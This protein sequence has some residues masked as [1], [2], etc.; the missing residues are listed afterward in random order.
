M[1]VCDHLNAQK[2]KMERNLNI[3][4]FALKAKLNACSEYGVK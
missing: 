1:E 3:V 2:W 4:M